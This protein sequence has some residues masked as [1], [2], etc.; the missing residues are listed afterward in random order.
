LAAIR[1]PDLDDA[2]CDV[3]GVPA[4]G[5]WPFVAC[6]ATASC[7]KQ[8]CLQAAFQAAVQQTTHAVR[9][10]FSG[11]VFRR[12]PPAKHGKFDAYR[13]GGL[14]GRL[15][16]FGSFVGQPILAVRMGLRPMKGDETS[17]R[18]NAPTVSLMRELAAASQ[19][20]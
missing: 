6:Q 11:F 9:R 12:H 18:Y 5:V 14:K 1:L 2:H 17:P 13:D 7:G 4:S 8:S 16:A 19:T 10:Y 15:S 20:G 3:A